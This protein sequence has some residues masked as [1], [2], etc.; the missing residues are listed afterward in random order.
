MLPPWEQFLGS[1][2]CGSVAGQREGTAVPW[3]ARTHT[4]PNTVRHKSCL[5]ASDRFRQEFPSFLRGWEGA[6]WPLHPGG[7]QKICSGGPQKH[8]QDRRTTLLKPLFWHAK[9]AHNAHA[10]I[11][12]NSIAPTPAWVPSCSVPPSA[13]PESHTASLGPRK[14][15]QHRVRPKEPHWLGACCRTKRIWVAHVNLTRF[16]TVARRAR[17]E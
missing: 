4:D 17:T 13:C 5:E 11:E 15:T 12:P 10:K 3:E 1:S 9:Q 2:L 14:D 8:P 6:I 16:F 7:N